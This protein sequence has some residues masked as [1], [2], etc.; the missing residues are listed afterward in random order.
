MAYDEHQEHHRY[1]EYPAHEGGLYAA[2]TAT[3]PDH[4][5]RHRR[6]LMVAST[7]TVVALIVSGF[8]AI[9]LMNQRQ[10][11]LPEPEAL[12]P[13]TTPAT[14]P[15]APEETAPVTL[16]PGVR[17]AAPVE[18]SPIP[19]IEP[20]PLVSPLVSRPVSSPEGPD[21]AEVR[22][23]IAIDEMR[24]RLRISERATVTEHPYA[25]GAMQVVG[26]RR[27]ATGEPLLRRATDRGVPAGNGIRCT[28]GVRNDRSADPGRPATLLCWRTS[29]SR[30]VV[31]VSTATSAG[32]EAVAVAVTLI[33]N[34]WRKAG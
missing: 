29:A 3:G 20:S 19:S 12:A 4:S 24:Q 22:A 21:P 33:E 30:S 23:S 2:G 1:D 18:R 6:Q 17:H 34:E 13:Q 10:A 14:I 5:A 26:F 11:T 31:V 8:L 16:T 28:T 32:A 27:D 15:V 7:V 25:D 9:Q